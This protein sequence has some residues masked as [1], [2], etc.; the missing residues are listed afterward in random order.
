MLRFDQLINIAGNVLILPR[1]R[2]WQAHAAAEIAAEGD[3][4]VEHAPGKS[5]NNLSA[6][7]TTGS[8]KYAKQL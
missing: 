8:R 4:P 5:F 7:N 1:Y 3:Q 6:R 2:F